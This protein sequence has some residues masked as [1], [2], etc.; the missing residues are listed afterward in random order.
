MR[1]EQGAA[2]PSPFGPLHRNKALSVGKNRQTSIATELSAGVEHHR[3]G[4]LKHASAIYRKILNRAPDNPDALHLLGVIALS[5]RRPERAI[6]LIGKAVAVSSRSAEAYSNLGNAQHAAGRPAEACASYRRAID[7]NPNFAAAHSNLGR[8]LCEEGDFAAALRSCERAVEIAPDLPE[9]HNN[10]GNALRGLGRWEAAEVAFRRALHLQPDNAVLHANLGNLLGDLKRFEEAKACYRR[11]IEIDPE[12]AV[13]HYGLA[14]C[15]RSLG[16]LAAATESYQKVLSLTPDQAF[17]WNDLGRTLR[18]LGRFEE[19]VAAFRQSLAV[20]PEF[21]E[22][23]RNLASCQQLTADDQNLARLSGLADQQDLPIE[24]RAA[25]GF[26]MGKVLDDADRFEE[27]FLAYERANRIYRDSRAAVGERFDAVEL[28]REVDEIIASFDSP[29]FA[30]ALDWGSASELPVF[31]VGM[32]RSGTSL[33]E[34][35]AASHSR[36]FGAGELREIGNLAQQLDPIIAAIRSGCGEDAAEAGAGHRMTIRRLSD[37]HLEHLKALNDRA[38]RVIDKMPDNIFKLGAIATLFTGARVIFCRRDPLDTCLSC[39]F[40]KFTAGQLGFSYDLADCAKRYLE[41]ERL[42]AHWRKV[43]PL[44][45]LNV[46]YEALVSDL[47]AQSR[48]IIRFLGF[49][50]EPACLDFHRTARTVTTAS[51]WQVRQPLY[52][53]AVGRWRKYQAHLAPLFELLVQG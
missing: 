20:N 24:E 48:R 33:V 46:E 4:R 37:A 9:A 38:E 6:Q 16:D 15:D 39:Y 50:W 52:D 23:Y 12:L 13:A 2:P 5:D 43:L 31:I 3:A 7:L 26:A 22:A 51:A 53:R 41:T 25:A 27:A 47:E 8:V 30:S 11:A 14:G 28:H 21:G 32:P 35:I 36:V 18:S 34:Q 49:D 29:F 44:S 10:F 45:W 42:T 40:Q 19:A 1:G 17:V